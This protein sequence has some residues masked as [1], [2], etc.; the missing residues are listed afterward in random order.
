M[1]CDKCGWPTGID[2][3][4]AE[5][6]ELTEKKAIQLLSSNNG[7][8]IDLAFLLLS[9]DKIPISSIGADAIM[10]FLRKGKFS[11]PSYWS[12]KCLPKMG[13]CG[14]AL[15]A[16][17]T[18]SEQSKIAEDAVRILAEADSARGGPGRVEPQG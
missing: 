18:R 13:T 8:D 16:E 4:S 10:N 15:L 17:F 7:K 1:I 9:D 2:P 12:M 14:I 5:G 11:H 3:E 6:H